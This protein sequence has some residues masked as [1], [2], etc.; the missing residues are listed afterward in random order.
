MSLC[1]FKNNERRT[2]NA[3]ANL[4]TEVLNICGRKVRQMEAVCTS[5][6]NGANTGSDVMPSALKKGKTI[7]VTGRGGP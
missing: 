1:L 6:D 2:S 7:P 3:V 4:N 5:T